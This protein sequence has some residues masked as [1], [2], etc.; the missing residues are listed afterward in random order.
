[1]ARPIK[2]NVLLYKLEQEQDRQLENYFSRKRYRVLV[3]HNKK[4]LTPFLKNY[5]FTYAFINE[6]E[7]D[8]T[9]KDYLKS[10]DNMINIITLKTELKTRNLLKSLQTEFTDNQKKVSFYKIGLYDYFV[11]EAILRF[12]TSDNTLMQY[13]TKKENAILNILCTNMGSMVFKRRIVMS[14][15]RKEDH[16]SLRSLDVYIARLRKYLSL[17]SNIQ[18]RTSHSRGLSIEVNNNK[19]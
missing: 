2:G 7:Q 13:L 11:D 14:V 16:A 3:A 4:Q 5:C 1:M 6:S 10:F 15:W 19:S 12:T 9:I 8:K 18:I 17:D